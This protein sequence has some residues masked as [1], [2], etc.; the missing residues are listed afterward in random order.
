[1]VFV[2]IVIMI[3]IIFVFQSNS[4]DF[5]RKKYEEAKNV[6]FHGKVAGKRQD[7]DYPRAARFL[8]LKNGYKKQVPNEIYAKMEIG[9]SV[10]KAK[11]KDTIYF[12]LKNGEVL[13][14]DYTKFERDKYLDLLAKE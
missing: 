7:G 4:I 1:M 2:P 6:E 10:C 11:G 9:D 5:N 13:V 14:H 8:I 3:I 12:Y